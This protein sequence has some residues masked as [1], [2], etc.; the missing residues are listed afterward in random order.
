MSSEA[1]VT[2]PVP[3]LVEVT[4]PVVFTTEPAVALVTFT[5]STQT[6]PAGTTPLV[7]LM[8]V[9]PARPPVKTRPQELVVE[10]AP[11]VTPGVEGMVEA[12]TSFMVARVMH[13]G[14]IMLFATGRYHDRIVLDGGEPRFAEKLVILDSRLI[15]TLLAIPL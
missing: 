4:A 13:S 8:L 3:P 9:L 2:L 10:T 15:D 1:L 6:P 5:T 7:T 11:L 12:Q 14:E